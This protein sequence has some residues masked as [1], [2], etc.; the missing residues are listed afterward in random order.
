MLKLFK[1]KS[2]AEKLQK[3]FKKSMDEW[4]KLSQINRSAADAKYAEA[5]QIAE[6]IKQLENV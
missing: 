1:K 3:Q 6:Q 5:E 2:K 4:H